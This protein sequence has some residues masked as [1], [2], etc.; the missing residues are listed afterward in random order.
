MSDGQ[1]RSPGLNL[2]GCFGAITL[3]ALLW[4][5]IIQGVRWCRAVLQGPYAHECFANLFWIALGVLALWCMW[6][7]ARLEARGQSG[8]KGGTHRL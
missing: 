6:Q 8:R 1:R 2:V 3:G 7:L 4:L 5:A